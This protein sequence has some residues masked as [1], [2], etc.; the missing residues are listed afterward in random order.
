M[1][2]C[3]KLYRLI[4]SDGECPNDSP[5]CE[6]R[7]E[8]IEIAKL[9]GWEESGNDRWFCARHAQAELDFCDKAKQL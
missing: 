6:T 1:I 5:R 2:I 8:L 9:L 4:C 3:E 7:E